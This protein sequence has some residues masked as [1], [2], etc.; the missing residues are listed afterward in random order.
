MEYRP[1]L[2]AVDPDDLHAL[3]IAAA[4]STEH[5]WMF[6]RALADDA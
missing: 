6:A 5:L 4:A 2:H 3:L 1:G